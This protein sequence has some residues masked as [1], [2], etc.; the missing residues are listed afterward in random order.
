MVLRVLPG[1]VSGMKR[2][3]DES[4][5]GSPGCMEYGIWEELWREKPGV[6]PGEMGT[7]VRMGW[8]AKVKFDWD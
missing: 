3:V 6:T 7:Q 8:E 5:V 1:Q 2:E 4:L